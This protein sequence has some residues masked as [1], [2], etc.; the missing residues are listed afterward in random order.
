MPI[1]YTQTNTTSTLTGSST[2]ALCSGAGLGNG[3]LTKDATEGGTPNSSGNG[4]VIIASDTND[5]C[6][7]YT[8]IISAATTWNAGTWTWRLNVT[9]ANM[10]VTLISVFIC[11][12][13]SSGTNQ[14]T[15]GSSTGLSVSMGSTGVKSGTI[16]G[17]AQSPG[18]GDV[19]VVMFCF[20]NGAMSNQNWNV[21]PDQNI[22]SP[23]TAITRQPRPTSI[24]HPFIV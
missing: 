24:G 13:N 1:N 6:V 7:K 12:V 17:S 15:I 10:N 5:W 3:L 22:D 14:A 20:S 16:S 2:V 11:R 8:C 19:V 18:V 21:A 23:F 9:T 4:L